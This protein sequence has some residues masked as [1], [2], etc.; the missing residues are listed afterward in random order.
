LGSKG[1]L[2]EPK[3]AIFNQKNQ[4]QSP[5]DPT[6]PFVQSVMM[7]KIAQRPCQAIFVDGIGRNSNRLPHDFLRKIIK[8]VMSLKGNTNQNDNFD[9]SKRQVTPSLPNIPD[10][11]VCVI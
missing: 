1:H 4:F 10:I 3:S 9:S 5:I 2:G 6:F 8:G 7:L 11:L